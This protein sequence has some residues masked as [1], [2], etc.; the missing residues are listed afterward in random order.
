MSPKAFITDEN[1]ILG[2]GG[3]VNKTVVNLFKL[4]K[5]K[6]LIY[7]QNIRAIKK[8]NFLNSNSENAFNYL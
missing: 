5:S 4:E 1:K 3:R 7:I 2:F 8:P 6:N